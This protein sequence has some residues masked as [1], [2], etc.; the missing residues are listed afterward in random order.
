MTTIAPNDAPYCPDL[1]CPN[2]YVPNASCSTCIVDSSM[3][4]QEAAVCNPCANPGDEGD[5]CG[6]MFGLPDDMRCCAPTEAC[7]SSRLPARGVGRT[8][9]TILCSDKCESQCDEVG[10][11]TCSPL[12]TLSLAHD[13]V[14]LMDDVVSC[15]DILPVLFNEM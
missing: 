9:P 1:S 6:A 15:T 5:Y 10:A 7:K 4:S 12:G 3:T 11:R 13:Q 8:K 2:C 14:G